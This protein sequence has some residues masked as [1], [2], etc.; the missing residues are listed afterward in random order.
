MK[1]HLLII[2]LIIIN[3]FTTPAQSPFTKHITEPDIPEFIKHLPTI[4]NIHIHYYN[5]KDGAG[6]E[7]NIEYD[8]P[9]LWSADH[10]KLTFSTKDIYGPTTYTVEYD[11]RR[12]I[13]FEETTYRNSMGSGSYGAHHYEYDK[14][15]LLIKIH[16][17]LSRKEY[18]YNDNEISEILSYGYD[19]YDQKLRLTSEIDYTYFDGYVLAAYYYI[20]F[21][22]YKLKYSATT[23]YDLDEE[24]HI[25]HSKQ[26]DNTN[27]SEYSY[28]YSGN[29][30]E[31]YT[32]HYGQQ[33]PYIREITLYNSDG[34]VKETSLSQPDYFG[35]WKIITSETYIYNYNSSINAPLA[36][37]KNNP[38]EAPLEIYTL[39][40][41]LIHKTSDQSTIN[42]FPKGIYIIKQANKTIKIL[43]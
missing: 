6:N 26:I 35:H 11:N 42:N 34:T 15:N 25:L 7:Y 27:G 30:V 37:D 16:T 21:S 32:H 38:V 22:D 10:S 40:G 5:Y 8:S 13:I 3:T 39:N 33:T 14:D 1:R 9:M 19:S 12:N 43:K 20:D 2:L 24:G 18:H 4:E 28:T 29:Y 36:I 41:T 17:D 23:R 31:K